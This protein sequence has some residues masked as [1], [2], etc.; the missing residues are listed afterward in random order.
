VS[1]AVLGL[2]FALLLG[3]IAYRAAMESGLASPMAA[4]L[5]TQIIFWGIG[6]VVLA[7]ILGSVVAYRISDPIIQLSEEIKRSGVQSHLWELRP[8]R[9]YHE[10]DLLTTTMKELAVA[11]SSREQA[12][13]ESERKF[14]ETFDLVDIGLVH[15]DPQGR[16]LLANRKFSEMLG[17]HPDEIIG[18]NLVDMTHPEDCGD[19]EL[20]LREPRIDG[21]GIPIREKRFLHKD[22]SIVWA[23]CSAVVI[24]DADGKPAY[25]L[26]AMEDISHYLA[27]QET[28]RS[29]NHSLRAIVETSPLAIF[30]ITPEGTVTLWNP[31]AEHL[32]G[33]DNAAVLGRLAPLLHGT[34][35][36]AMHGILEHVL[37]GKTVQ[38]AAVTH[39][40][41][42]ETTLELS[43]SA[44]LLRSDDDKVVGVLVICT[45]ITNLKRVEHAL[46]ES[47]ARFRAL[48]ESAMDIVTVLD[49]DGIIR[50]QSPSV[51]NILGYNP[52][53]MI[54]QYQFD[55]V[56]PDDCEFVKSAHERLIREN[57]MGRPVEFQVRHKDG[58]WRTLE[59]IAKNSLDNPHIRGVIVNT[60]DVTER[61]LIQQRIQHLAYHDSLTGLPNRSLLQDRASQAISRAERTGKKLAVM[62]IDIDN[63]KNV[64]D[65]LGHDVG[66]ELLRQVASRLRSSVRD[67]DTIARQG[68]DE[69]IVLL[70]ELDG[71]RGAARVAQKIL[72]AL[73]TAFVVGGTTQHVSGSMGIALHPEDGNDPQTLMK[74]ADTAMFHGKGMGKNTYQ[75]FTH[76]MNIAVKRRAILESSLRAAAKD[77][78]FTLHYQPQIDLV[79]G[80]IVAVES[81]IRWN[82]QDGG[83]M[84]PGEF[85]PL[86]EENGLISQIG[87]WVLREGCRQAKSWQDK[88]ITHCRV[89]INLSTR[90]LGDKGFVDMVGAILRETGLDPKYLELE[91]TES[92]VMR[93][94]EGSIMQLNKLADMGI[95]LAVD[96][97]GTGYSS[98]SYLKRLPI[99]K[100]KIDQSFIRDIT[101]DPNDTAIVVA[102]I[103]MAKSLD[104]EV[105]AEGIETAGQLKLLRAKG[106][107]IGQGYYF[108]VPMS[109]D[110]ILPFLRQSVF[111]TDTET[112]TS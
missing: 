20:L 88:N 89:A 27:T 45:D 81:L 68:G 9:S 100:L 14:R 85:I 11:V 5:R 13:V 97:F 84:M 104:L 31:A 78:D 38:N 2:A 75:F 19:D 101:I 95:Q 51:R 30:A 58:T 83:T 36:D 35:K 106:C 92:Q 69:F 25:A 6:A 110:S 43:V 64:N 72:E 44:A 73:R 59:S 86:A 70:E 112:V 96:D 90:Q 74:N 111:L 22:G 37:S 108:S 102:I 23:R 105:I 33:Q 26:G 46:E 32:F 76:Q 91:I 103:N 93:Q 10:L 47:E 50:Y 57:I 42:S 54:G 94:A 34:G 16:Y 60:R 107:N 21:A 40:R 1:F 63:F 29:L 82:S 7:A 15:L 65:T 17:Y 3:V 41:E 4:N 62:F 56:H 80:K 77:G 24:R 18:L 67:H 79:S 109:A 87:E 99:R 66:D 28:L 39:Q 98:L 12:L 48:T 53:K 52:E 49:E 71:Q 61:N 55:L 8:E